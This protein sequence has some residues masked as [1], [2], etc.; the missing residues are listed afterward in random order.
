MNLPAKLSTEGVSRWLRSL[1]PLVIYLAL[2]FAFFGRNVN[3]SEYYFG[4]SNDSLLFIWFLHW[5]PFALSHGLNPFITKY[6]WYPNGYNVTWSTSLG[7]FALIAWPVTALGGPVLSYNILMLSAP[8]LAGWTGFLLC[9]E[10]T[11]NWAASLIGGLFFGFSAPELNQLAAELNLD[12]VFLIPLAALLCLRHLR[13][14]LRRWPFIIALSLLLVAQLGMSTEMLAAL[15]LSGALCWGIFLTFAPAAAQPSYWRLAA[16]IARAAPLVMLLAAPFLYYLVKGLPDFP[17]HIHPP[18]FQETDALQFFIP[19]TPVHSLRA[20]LASILQQCAGIAPDFFAYLSPPL[21]L[22]LALYFYRNIA[23]SYVKA[24]LACAC[25]LAALSLG[26]KLYINGHLTSIPLPW[27]IF[28]HI[29]LIGAIMPLRFLSFLTLATAVAAALYLAGAKTPAARARRYALAALACIFLPPAHV[30]VL[31]QPWQVLPI[32]QR[33]TEYKWLRWPTHPFFTPEHI[34]QALGPMPNVLLLPDPVVGP[35]MAWQIDA[36]MGFTQAEGY[37]G[38]TYL[39]EQKWGL[40]DE[41]V[42]NQDPAFSTK[43]Q[44]FCAAHQVDDI[45]IAPGTPPAITTAIEALGWPHHMDSGIEV[46][47]APNSLSALTHH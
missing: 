31:P 19:A 44:A 22:I 28:S 21:W 40:A 45:L 41:L 13:G 47:K 7:F 2:S 33:Q 6:A 29:P 8:A 15:C 23:A 24:L 18:G 12:S 5:W 38:Y 9:R 26:L 42:W 30:Q 27:A 4:D 43:F 36:G 37:V 3:W 34:R 11:G 46:I 20:A 35:G 16:D 17:S 39:P 1:A 32:F 25:L 10:L 14:T